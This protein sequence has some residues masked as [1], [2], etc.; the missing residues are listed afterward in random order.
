M[1]QV[2]AMVDMFLEAGYTYFDTAYGYPG[3]EA[4][5]GE[6][7]VKR[8]PRESYLLAT[9]LPAWAGPKNADEAKRMFYTSLSAPARVTLTITF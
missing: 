9:K 8:H 3:S 6:A 1:E 4:A 2:K 5:A 7:L